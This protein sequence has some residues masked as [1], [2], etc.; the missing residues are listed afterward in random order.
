MISHGLLLYRRSV[1]KALRTLAGITLVVTLTACSKPAAAP[2]AVP[3]KVNVMNVVQRKA[4]ITGEVVGEVHALREV[5]LRPQVTGLVVKR[6][7]EPGQLVREGQPLFVIDPRPYESAVDEAVAEVA[8]TRSSLARARQDVT[9]YEP[10]VPENAIPKATYDQ[11]VA[12]ANS[13]AAGLQARE[14]SLARSRLDL[15]NTVVRSPVSGRIGL[16][17]LE[18]G[19][20]AS[21]GQSVLA[22]VSTLDPV[23]VY[24]SIP[25]SDFVRYARGTA[26]TREEALSQPVSLVLPD[27]SRYGLAGKLDF[28]ERSIDAGTGTLSMRARFPNPE[29]NLR[30]GMSVRVRLIYEQREDALLIPQRAVTEVLNQRF[31][32]VLDD[33]NKIELRNVDLAEREGA[34]WLVR[35][36]LKAGDRIVVDGLQRVRNGTVV[37][38]TLLTTAQFE[39]SV[40]PIGSQ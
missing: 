27:G 19:S 15:A 39:E 17:K 8:D 32:Y 12:Q 38:P 5:E 2:P 14:A 10:L 18:V 1:V 26:A 31:V 16:Q 23:L 35:R 13:A 24:F 34:W 7:F 33:G 4:V 25:E 37:D 40:A 30:P 29:Q 36:G 6:L 22:I 20:L 9:R 3:A 28:V 21:A 11:A